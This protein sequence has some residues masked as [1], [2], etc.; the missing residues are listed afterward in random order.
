MAHPKQE[1]RINCYMTVSII[2]LLKN[3]SHKEYITLPVKYSLTYIILVRNVHFKWK[4][5]LRKR[6]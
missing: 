4:V 1:N 5:V 6:Y 2:Y 3:I